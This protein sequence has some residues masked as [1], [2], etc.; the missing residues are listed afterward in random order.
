MPA[1]GE[2]NC[3][4]LL[5]ILLLLL[6]I[7]LLSDRFFDK[8]V[9]TAFLSWS[10]CEIVIAVLQATGIIDP[11]NSFFLCTGSFNNSG[12][13]SGFLAITACVLVTYSLKCDNRYLKSVLLSVASIEVF[14]I[15]L[16]QSRASV[17]ALMM[18]FLFFCLRHDK[19][20]LWIK[21]HWPILL[22]CSGL[23]FGL[24]Y[25]IKKPSADGRLF[26]NRMSVSI[27]KS[28]GLKGLKEINYSGAYGVEQ[29][30]YFNGQMAQVD[31]ILNCEL[32]DENERITADCPEYAFNEFLWIG[33]EYG[34]VA[35]LFFV[36]ILI[37]SIYNSFIKDRPWLYGII[38]FSVFAFFSY[39]LHTVQIQ[40]LLC[41]LLVACLYRTDVKNKWIKTVIVLSISLV[42]LGYELFYDP[43]YNK[44]IQQ[45][46]KET[47]RWYLLGEYEFV[48]EGCDTLLEYKKKDKDF[49]FKYGRALHLTG[50][51]LKSDSI[52]ELG[53]HVS[54]DPMFWNIMGNN[55]L[56]LGRYRE[57][58]ERYMHAFLMVPNRLYP[59][60]LLTK[61]YYAEGDYERARK[62][63]KM[64]M[65]FK[66]KVESATTR[67]LRNE[68][69]DLVKDI[70]DGL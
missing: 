20:R 66:P 28:N 26:I 4:E 31:G 52:L 48:T 55:S 23:L 21:Q 8:I 16:L 65:A 63:A 53:T 43:K 45:D 70:P 41:I 6:A 50:D 30:K 38:S 5:A 3:L 9:A 62:M 59:L 44:T 25:F 49:L 22:V 14:L 40:I 46:W 32:L 2:L 1:F 17:L 54:S 10:I 19:C 12:P 60:C 57:A 15:F 24:L 13:F 42:S 67:E 36:G 11:I 61:L 7:S 29:F 27:M 37:V 33:A 18:C 64:V 39:P 35:I 34:I 47:N 69:A 51:Y 58:E 68:I 56:A